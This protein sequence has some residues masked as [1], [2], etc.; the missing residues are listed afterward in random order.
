M[1]SVCKYGS[2]ED[3]FGIKFAIIRLFFLAEIVV[4]GM[5]LDSAIQ[6]C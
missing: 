5:L 6:F 2:C 4:F 3:D 1:H